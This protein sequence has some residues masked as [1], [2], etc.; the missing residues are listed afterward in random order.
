MRR[1]YPMSAKKKRVVVCYC[2][3]DDNKGDAAITLGVANLLSQASPDWEITFISLFAENESK[4]VT[5]SN[6]L[7]KEYPGV[8][9][10]GSLVRTIRNRF[11]NI[12]KVGL[13]LGILEELFLLAFPKLYMCIAP[14]NTKH[15]LK[16]FFSADIIIGNGGHVFFSFPDNNSCSWIKRI[17]RFLPPL[18]DEGKWSLIQPF[19]LARR[20]HI[21]YGFLAHSFGPFDERGKRLVKWLLSGASFIYCRESIS[22]RNI[23]T[24]SIGKKPQLKVVPDGAFLMPDRGLSKG[25]EVLE[26]HGLKA[27][28][29]LA[30]TVRKSSSR[31]LGIPSKKY[32]QYLRKIAQVIDLWIEHERLPVVVIPQTV[33]PESK[34]ENDIAVGCELEKLVS[35]PSKLIIIKE[36]LDIPTLRFLYKQALVL[37]GSRLHSIIFALLESTPVLAISSY[38]F[39]P[40]TL[41]IMQDI[42]LQDYVIDMEELEPTQAFSILQNLATNRNKMEKRIEKK[43]TALRKQAISDVREIFGTLDSNQ[44]VIFYISA[45]NWEAMVQREQHLYKELSKYYKVSY[46]QTVS[47]KKPLTWLKK[48]PIKVK[49]ISKNLSIIEIPTIPFLGRCQFFNKNWN[50]WYIY[51]LLKVRFKQYWNRGNVILGTGCPKFPIVFRCLPASIKYYDCMDNRPALAEAYGGDVAEIRQAEEEI[52]KYADYIFVTADTLKELSPY[53]KDAITVNNGVD[54]SD[55]DIVSGYIPPDVPNGKPIIGYCG[56]LHS[57]FDYKTIML[58]AKHRPIYNFVLIGPVAKSCKEILKTLTQ[59]PNVFWLGEKPYSMLAHY[60]RSF[61]VATIPFKVNEITRYVDPVKIYEYFAMGK[62]VV[63]SPL[64]EVKKW[65]P[66]VN[67]YSSSEE[68]LTALDSIIKGQHP[69]FSV[70]RAIAKNNTWGHR[71]KLIRSILEDGVRPRT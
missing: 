43:V 28:Q 53:R 49:N 17:I 31:G 65:Q 14:S 20:L 34:N 51:W 4:F 63:A 47:I 38:L 24:L 52:E 35:N 57:W 59:M 21:P 2:W 66:Y 39:G 16:L 37:M 32:I 25:G 1:E 44:P 30:I 50:E 19:I 13:V 5:T 29:F 40:K 55:F 68:F 41:G 6:Y 22:M 61:D 62:P 8:R 67:I 42:G 9:I 36:K 10:V 7:L 70:L 23:L 27:N 15:L 3:P 12:P 48:L 18:Q 11:R 33:T 58:A 46:L 69:D 56:A 45:A 60:I 54:I 26:R 71:A 64:P